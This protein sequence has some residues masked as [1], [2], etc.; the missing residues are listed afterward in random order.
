[1]AQEDYLLHISKHTANYSLSAVPKMT[2]PDSSSNLN[3]T[4]KQL[5]LL[6]LNKHTSASER[7]NIEVVLKT[8]L[9]HYLPPNVYVV[10][11]SDAGTC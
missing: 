11:I 3:E 5:W 2:K 1:M 8:H 9:N 4:T 7:D 6:Q 10:Y